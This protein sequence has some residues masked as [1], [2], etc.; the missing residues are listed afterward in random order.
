[1]FM[2]EKEAVE[3]YK[4]IKEIPPDNSEEFK[5]FFEYFENTYFSLEKENKPKYEFS[6]WNYTDKLKIEGTKYILFE[7]NNYKIN[8]NFSNNCCESLNH[9]ING[10]LNVNNS[11]SMTKFTEIIK[12]IFIRF[13]MIKVRKNQKNE[14]IKNI[15]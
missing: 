14:K 9:L 10:V 12:F 13:N 1:M 4:K 15:T 2:K 6:L 3:F 5:T 7:E 8:F 11:V